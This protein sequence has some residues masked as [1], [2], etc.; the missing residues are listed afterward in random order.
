MMRSMVSTLA[1]S[2]AVAG[3]DKTPVYV[4]LRM[5]D[6]SAGYVAEQQATAINWAIDNNVK[7]TFGVIA[8]SYPLDCLT[9]W[10]P[11][12]CNDKAVKALNDA[13]TNGHVL[14]NPVNGS[15]PIIEIADHA[16]GH[17][18]WSN[19]WDSWEHPSATF[20]AWQANDMKQSK[21]ALTQA[22]PKASVRTF[23]A[24]Q[25]RA[26]A[27]TLTAMQ[28]V[29]LDIISAQA[30]LGCV[31]DNPGVAPHYNY[32]YA[33]C[34]HEDADGNLLA[35]CVPEGDV[36]CTVDGGFQSLPN[37]VWSAP[38]GAANSN[39]ANV[40][41]G[42]SVTDTLGIDKCGCDGDNACPIIASAQQLADKSNG[43]HWTVVMMH[44]Q[45]TFPGGQTY[46][47][48][49]QELKSTAENLADYE[50]KFITFQDLVELKLPQAPVV[51]V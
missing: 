31:G 43:L 1:A 28:A 20:D 38:G 3:A 29:G 26:T 50:L 9:R 48:W 27:G 42:L 22:F 49:L 7:F 40:D 4:V 2:V 25:C 16:W 41:N 39:M 14:G 37:N 45:T 12:D 51:T 34:E 21:E 24:P 30:Q 18:E 11:L 19:Q 10:N 13:Y 35:D 47:Q 5:D 44:P 46:L 8:S 15:N 23:I 32:M 36:Y 17:E 33:P 6:I